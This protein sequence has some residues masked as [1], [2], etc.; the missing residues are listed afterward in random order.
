VNPSSHL[1]HAALP[2]RWA[3]RRVK[4]LVICITSGSRGWAEHYSDT[5]PIFIR[6]GNLSR[7]SIDLDLNEIQRVSPPAGTE[8]ERT[9]VLDGDVLVSVTAFVGTVGIVPT[10]L[11][12]AY[13][14]QHTALVRPNLAV[15][16][17]RWL[18][19]TFFSAPGQDQFRSATY[20][21]T[22]EGLGLEDVGDVA[23][24]LPPLPEQRAIVTYLDRKTAEIDAVIAAKE[25]MLGLLRE[26]RNALVS[27]AVTRGLDTSVPTK[28]SC[29]TGLQVVPAHWR[30]LALR[31]LLTARPAN[32]ISPP[33]AGSGGVPSFSVA[34]LRNGRV[35]IH[36]HLKHVELD[37]ATASAYRLNQ[38]DILA[39][40]GNANLDLV[41]SVGMVASFPEG[42]TYPDILIR[43]TPNRQV[44]RSFLV[45]AL[46]ACY[47][48][49]QIE[50]AAKTSNGTYKVSGEDIS[51]LRI[52]LPPLAE[53]EAICVY[54]DRETGRT[55]SLSGLITNQI[56]KLREYRHAVITAAV[57]GK[58]DVGAAEAA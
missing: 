33:P 20:G 17:P 30:E 46:N 11:G 49:W 45:A 31:H 36:D 29:I 10:G 25:R 8:G 57:T 32:G 48:R 42:C 15:V 12:D 18:A 13:V 54:L 1:P 37:Q 38:G 40:R 7:H 52:A 24:P 35:N 50:T 53:Q 22:K 19:Y 6:I 14:N 2:Q 4:H 55:D 56:A 9:K 16:E 23:V 28:H 3:V 41:G 43:L 27:Q 39:M 47:C 44:S 51:E 26:K 21:G 58:I 34:A 5:G